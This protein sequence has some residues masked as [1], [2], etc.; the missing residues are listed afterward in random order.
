MDSLRSTLPY[1]RTIESRISLPS[2]STLVYAL[3]FPSATPLT[4]IALIAHPLGRLGGSKED[5]VVVRVADALVKEGYCVCRY[6]A[7]GAGRS[8]GSP[9]FS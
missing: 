2:G 3:S 8:E 5:H 1:P 9:S 6:D 4:K 7:R